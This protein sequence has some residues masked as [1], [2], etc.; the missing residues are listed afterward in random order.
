MQV[1]PKVETKEKKIAESFQFSHSSTFSPSFPHFARI[2]TVSNWS[3]KMGDKDLQ[4]KSDENE[5]DTW[6]S[7]FGNRRDHIALAQ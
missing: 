6:D 4:G 1:R 3:P 7:H 2:I 5:N